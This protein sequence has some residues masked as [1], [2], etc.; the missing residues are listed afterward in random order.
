MRIQLLSPDSIL[1]MWSEISPLIQEALDTGQGE[2]TLADHMRKLMNFEEHCW[3]ITSGNG[4]ILG[5]GLTEF[6]QYTQHKTLHIITVTGNN[7]K[8]WG[9]QVFPTIEQFAKDAGCKAVEQWGR[10][11]W[12]KVLPNLV[13]GFEQAYVV[14][15]KN[16]G[17]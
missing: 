16:I 1:T 5:V 8:E 13:P 6:I 12:A 15:R 2:N 17:E 10:P 11:G 3:L 7:F 14:M 4:E 9:G